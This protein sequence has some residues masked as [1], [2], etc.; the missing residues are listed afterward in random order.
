MTERELYEKIKETIKAIDD[1]NNNRIEKGLLK[2][3]I[4][5]VMPDL[6]QKSHVLGS[7]GSTCPKCNGTGRA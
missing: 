7:A 2:S 3:D 6:I 4:E 1:Y 5:K